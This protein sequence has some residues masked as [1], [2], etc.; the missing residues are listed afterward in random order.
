MLE[1]AEVSGA[2]GATSSFFSCEFLWKKVPKMELRLALAAGTGVSAFDSGLGSSA[3]VG[4]AA[5]EK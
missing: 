3:G 5:K 4:A 2:L 1:T